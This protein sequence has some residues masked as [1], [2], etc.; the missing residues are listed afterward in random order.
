[1]SPLHCPARVRLAFAHHRCTIL[2]ALGGLA[3]K[4]N[5]RGAILADEFRVDSAKF[6]DV[7]PTFCIDACGGPALA[8]RCHRSSVSIRRPQHRRYRPL[9]YTNQ[10]LLTP[11]N[12]HF[13]L[14]I[15]AP[16][17][18]HSIA[19]PVCICNLLES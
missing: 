10:F 12:L 6:G 9:R 17:P 18:L 7:G 3:G 16:F 5:R 2:H 8:L 11:L 15:P 14:K 4:A 1:M 19:F 13:Y